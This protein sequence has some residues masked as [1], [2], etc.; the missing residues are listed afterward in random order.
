MLDSLHI[1]LII[2]AIVLTAGIVYT[3]TK[4]DKV[5]HGIFEQNALLQK[6]LNNKIADL[7]NTQQQGITLF[8]QI[9]DMNMEPE[10]ISAT[11]TKQTEE[12]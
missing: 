5:L 1:F 6:K 11:R 10:L 4:Y 8:R 3:K 7:V 12:K 9:F 2:L